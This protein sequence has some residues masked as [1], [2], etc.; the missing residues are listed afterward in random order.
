MASHHPTKFGGLRQCRS[1]DMFFVVE[2]QDSTCSRLNQL[3]LFF[4][5]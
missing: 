1:G 3:L 4:F 5:V 2:E